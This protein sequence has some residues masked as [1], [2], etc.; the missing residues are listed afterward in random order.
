MIGPRSLLLA[1]KFSSSSK[2]IW[3]H[4]PLET[5]P[6][7]I[8][9]LAFDLDKC[10]GRVTHN[11]RCVEQL[12][13]SPSPRF[14]PTL[15]CNF[16]QRSFWQGIP[17]STAE[18]GIVEYSIAFPH[19][20]NLLGL[21]AISCHHL[22]HPNGLLFWWP[23]PW[24]HCQFLAFLCQL[25]LLSSAT[26]KF[27][28]VPHFSN[29]Y[30]VRFVVKHFDH[31]SRIIMFGRPN[32]VLFGNSVS[33]V[34]AVTV[35]FIPYWIEQKINKNKL[36]SLQKYPVSCMHDTVITNWVLTKWFLKSEGEVENLSI[37]PPIL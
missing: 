24:F 22:H 12:R 20:L 13:H 6:P 9:P 18:Y 30:P 1:N 23:V 21:L 28:S 16:F 19:V 33:R 27:C 37:K 25:F 17:V 35:A 3:S 11:S 26:R 4:T 31:L 14:I 2:F 34:P 15:A 32:D 36:K 29:C 7:I 5:W 10:H 8:T